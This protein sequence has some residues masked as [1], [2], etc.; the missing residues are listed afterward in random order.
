LE[1]W[2][3]ATGWYPRTAAL[4]EKLGS[5]PTTTVAARM[6]SELRDVA[7]AEAVV[8]AKRDLRVIANS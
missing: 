5:V 3:P 4:A 1:K 6:R 8:A 2:L 7:R